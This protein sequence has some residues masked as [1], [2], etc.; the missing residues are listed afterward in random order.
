MAE[1]FAGGAR[2]VLDEYGE[3]GYLRLWGNIRSRWVT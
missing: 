2:E 3:D 1:A